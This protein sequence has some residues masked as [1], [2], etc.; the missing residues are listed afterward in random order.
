MKIVIVGSGPAGVTTVETLR[1]HDDRMEIVLLS[2]EPYPPYS[3]PAM[4]DH[5]LHDSKSHLWRDEDWPEKNNVHYLPG[6]E[7]THLDLQQN[8]LHLSTGKQLAY[9]HLV[10]ATGSRLYAPLEGAELPGVY[11]FKSLSAAEA[12]IAQVRSGAAKS[13]V[14]I[15]A[16]FIG[17]EIGLLLRELGVAVTQLEML[18][19]VM[20][21]MLNHEAASLALQVMRE[22]GIDVRLNTR[23]REIAGAQRAQ[24]VVLESGELV[25]ADVYIAATGVKPNVDFLEGSGVTVDWG[26]PVDDHL[27]TNISNIFA[28]GD[29]IEAPDRLTGERYV[30][31][32]FPNAV[33][34]GRVV[35]L[36]LTGIETRYE[37]ADRMNSLKHLGVPIMAVGVKEGDEVLRTRHNGS[38][39]TLYLKDDRIVGF[40]LIGELQPA[41]VLRSLMNR[42]QDIRPIKH[43]LLDASF[44]VGV[45]LAELTAPG[46]L[47][48]KAA[49]QQAVR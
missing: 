35:G 29:V 45:V 27:R 13:A 38:T 10:I 41:G 30:H 22:R 44:G 18:N 15:G 32:I 19:Q 8:Q 37:G 25:S 47:T 20:P 7:A 40:Q 23:V 17:M 2:A 9:D 31:A 4:A 49:A 16:G 12:L 14:I 3:P 21:H 43:R 48:R 39:R 24:G 28:A 5:F 46:A 34:Q 36:N 42:R 11:N 33:A 6:V 26:I 1:T